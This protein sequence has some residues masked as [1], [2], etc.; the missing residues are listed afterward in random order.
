MPPP[1][2]PPVEHGEGERQRDQGRCEKQMPR[3][4][5]T[6][7]RHRF[8]DGEHAAEGVG[9]REEIRQLKAADHREVP[10]TW[11]L[12]R[13]HREARPSAGFRSGTLPAEAASS[14]DFVTLSAAAAAGFSVIFAITASRARLKYSRLVATNSR[15]VRRPER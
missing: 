12:G 7:K 8:E 3:G 5:R 6:E 13:G 11:L 4:A 1:R 9:D 10:V 14:G 15:E 2:D